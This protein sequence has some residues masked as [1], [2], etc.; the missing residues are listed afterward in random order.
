MEFLLANHPLDCPICDEGGEC[1]LQDQVMLF[2]GDRG[3]FNEVKRSVEDKDFGPFIKGTMTRCIHCTRCVRFSKEV[4]GCMN[5]GT[6]GR[7]N[8]MEIGTYVNG[9][10]DSEVSGNVIDLCP[11]GALTSKPYAFTARSWELRGT[12]SV[13]VTDAV[14]SAIRIDCRGPEVMRVLPRLNEDVNEEWIHD[15][16]RFSYDGLKRQRLD[17]PMVQNAAGDF[18]PVSWRDALQA[19]RAQMESVPGSS[20]KAIAG[21][22]VDA[23]AL[24]ALKDLL[25]R[26]GSDNYECRQDGARVSADV[27]SDYCFNSTIV[28]IEEADLV[29]L[30]GSNPRM[31]AP[32]VNTR[33]RKMIEMD[34]MPVASIGPAADLSYKHEHLGTDAATLEAI[35]GGKHA[36]SKKLAAAKRP[37]IIVGAGATRRADGEAVLRAVQA[38]AQKNKNVM[39]EE[40]NGVSVLQTAASRTAGLDLGFTPGP[41]A[42][43]SA[44]KIVYLLGADEFDES[45][46]P[47]DAF[48]IYQGHHG[49]RGASR[50]NVILPGTAFSEKNGTF[51]N[52]EGRVQRTNAA[53]NP[54]GEAREDWTIVR[55]LSEEL[56]M[57]LPYSSL[58]QV[59]ERLVDVAP[60]FAHQDVAEMA[61]FQPVAKAQALAKGDFQRTVDNFFFTDVIGRS[62]R[63]M[64]KASATL[65][66]ATNSYL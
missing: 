49:D 15:K 1:D 32:M 20:I 58:E 64:A 63:S 13:D 47:A 37:L 28:G 3:R 55:A 52:T 29:L 42:D 45:S 8:E 59:R 9:I 30:V 36:F 56:D 31:E 21:N 4:A 22:M 39:N 46:I 51:V 27:R 57:P 35:L 16:A 7:G 41:D 6:S 53:C 5:M 62:S 54:V 50:A 19:V 60:H 61:S 14:G 18:E 2:G 40:W 66:K 12:E 24:I 23:E 48:V 65:D 11:V 26:L 38:Y 17:V 25:N 44:T 34:G 43:N 10:L 33:I